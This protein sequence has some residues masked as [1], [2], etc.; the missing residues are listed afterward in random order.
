[1]FIVLQYDEYVRWHGDAST[2]DKN[3]SDKAGNKSGSDKRDF[4]S[5]GAKKGG[6]D[7]IIMYCATICNVL[8]CVRTVL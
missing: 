2:T 4:D 5:S 8:S 6:G 7:V 1:M 3:S